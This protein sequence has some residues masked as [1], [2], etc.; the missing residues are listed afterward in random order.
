MA[1]LHTSPHI[2]V[3]PGAINF[4]FQIEDVDLEDSD[5]RSKLEEVEPKNVQCHQSVIDAEI[6]IRNAIPATWQAIRSPQSDAAGIG[7]TSIEDAR[8]VNTTASNTTSSNRSQIE[9]LHA[10]PASHSDTAKG[11]AALMNPFKAETSP[12]TW[13]AIN[14][15]PHTSPVHLPM[16]LS[17]A[18]TSPETW[19]A[20]K[21]RLHTSPVHLPLNHS[22]SSSLF[23]DRVCQRQTTPASMRIAYHIR[24]LTQARQCYEREHSYDFVKEQLD[25]FELRAQSMDSSCEDFPW[26]MAAFS[27]DWDAFVKR[28]KWIAMELQRIEGALRKMEKCKERIL[29]VVSGKKGSPVELNAEN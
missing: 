16:N 9:S 25:W 11:K 14:K 27:A 24:K 22:Q 19:Q 4:H 3:C 12:G 8:Q 26:E 20:I 15:P 5:S 13:Q 17:K 18:D 10:T 21:K 2:Q 23:K 7:A 29:K 1:S 6:R 28:Q